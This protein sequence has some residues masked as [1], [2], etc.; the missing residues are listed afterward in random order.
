MVES[1]E[2][3]VRVITRYHIIEQ[4]Y[5]NDSP[6]DAGNHVRSSIVTVYRAISSFLCKAQICFFFFFFFSL[7]L[8][9]QNGA[10]ECAKRLKHSHN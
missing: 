5:C 2:V 9:C 1:L 7:F 8:F 4:M 3:V 6:T 10:N